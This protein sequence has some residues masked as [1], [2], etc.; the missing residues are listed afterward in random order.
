MVDENDK[1]EAIEENKPKLKKPP[2]YRKFAKLLR[3]VIAAPPL[4]TNCH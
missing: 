1:V 3:Q 2:G 4:K